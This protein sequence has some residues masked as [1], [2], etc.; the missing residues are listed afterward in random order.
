MNLLQRLGFPL[1]VTSS[2]APVLGAQLDVTPD[3]TADVPE[4][5]QTP[6]QQVPV[7]PVPRPEPPKPAAP[8]WTPGVC[9]HFA[10]FVY[11]GRRF[12]LLLVDDVHATYLPC[13][14]RNEEGT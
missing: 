10:H 4:P 13:E 3:V 7:V 14:H 8:S 9:Y 12:G 2:S 1:P 5:V 6:V 11:Q